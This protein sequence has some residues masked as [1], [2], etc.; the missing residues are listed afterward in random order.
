MFGFSLFFFQSQ[1]KRLLVSFAEF[2][3]MI[4]ATD[5]EIAKLKQT[6]TTDAKK[7]IEEDIEQ[8]PS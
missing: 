1:T 8:D 4:E 6:Q 7:V 3:W 5:D 2:L